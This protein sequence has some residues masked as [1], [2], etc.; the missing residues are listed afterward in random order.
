VREENHFKHDTPPVTFS[1]RKYKVDLIQTLVN[2]PTI[3]V[4]P[5]PVQTLHCSN[6]YINIEIRICNNHIFLTPRGSRAIA[7]PITGTALVT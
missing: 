4:F 7:T 2:P 5:F 1:D 3:L 6:Q